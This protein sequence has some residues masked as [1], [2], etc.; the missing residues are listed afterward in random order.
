MKKTLIASTVA[1]GL[2][3]TGVAGGHHSADAA[4]QGVNKAELANLAQ[5][6]P[7]QLN[8][9]PVQKGSYNYDFTYNG[10]HYHFE[11]NGSTWSWSWN[12]Y[13]ESTQQNNT[14]QES[15]NVN[16]QQASAQQ[17]QQQQAPQTAQTQQPKQEAT[18]SAVQPQKQTTQVSS[19]QGSTQEA[20]SNYSGGTNS[21]LQAIKQRESGGDY[22]AQNPTTSASGAY[23]IMD[24]TWNAYAP[25]AYKGMSAKDAPK[26]VQDHVAQTIY[27][28]AGASQWVTA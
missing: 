7:A 6:N 20:S 2:G 23:Q 18:T 9:S 13:G 27:D 14:K 5:N 15:A 17:P 24:E 10:N 28:Q 3:V 21:H 4:E 19:N 12:G 1:L 25:S 16:T 22:K 26:N 11:S 8:E